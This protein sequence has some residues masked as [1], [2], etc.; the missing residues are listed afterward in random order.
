MTVKQV[1]R[2]VQEIRDLTL[3]GINDEQARSARDRLY[4][5]VLR[6]IAGANVSGGGRIAGSNAGSRR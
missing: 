3:Q 2:R 6:A 1:Q 4:V 5:D